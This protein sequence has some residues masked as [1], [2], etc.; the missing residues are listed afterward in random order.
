MSGRE[1]GSHHRHA[2]VSLGKTQHAHNGRRRMQG[3]GGGWRKK[4]ARRRLKVT[5]EP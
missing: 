4:R 3:K 1:E 5:S 2:R